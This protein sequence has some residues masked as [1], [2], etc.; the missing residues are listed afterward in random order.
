MILVMVMVVSS[1]MGQLSDSQQEKFSRDSPRYIKG[2]I[3]C[4]CS[5]SGRGVLPE[6]IT[7]IVK[8]LT[9]GNKALKG[10]NG[11]DVVESIAKSKVAATIQYSACSKAVGT[12]AC[13]NAAAAARARFDTPLCAHDSNTGRNV[14]PVNDGYATVGACSTSSEFTSPKLDVKPTSTPPV[15]TTTKNVPAKPSPSKSAKPKAAASKSNKPSPSK[16]RMPK[17]APSKNRIPRPS[18]A[19]SPLTSALPPPSQSASPSMSVWPSKTCSM[20]ASPSMTPAKK[21]RH[22]GCVAIQHLHGYV[23]QHRY[24]LRRLVLCANGFCATPNHEIE[25]RGVRTSM[26]KLCVGQWNCVHVVKLVNNLKL[27]SNRRARVN[28]DI[29]VTPYDHRFPRWTIWIVQMAEDAIELLC[30]CAGIA[31]A[32]TIS[33]MVHTRK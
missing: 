5:P 28:D 14:I 32:V 13:I 27:A 29:V 6:A 24:H 30:A 23:L 9:D 12:E 4:A 21:K 3:S 16:S 18:K 20:S 1:A 11:E 7:W 2:L 22:E 17:P 33:L 8:A 26:R 19:A 15:T 10:G 31:I 25:F